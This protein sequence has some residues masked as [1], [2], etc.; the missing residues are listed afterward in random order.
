[1]SNVPD[2]EKIER[3]DRL[4]EEFKAR[5]RNTVWPDQLVNSKGVD[6]FLWH[7]SPNPTKVQRAGAVV[8]GLFFTVAAISFA[9]MALESHS[10][11]LALVALGGLYLA[12]RMLRN[13]FPKKDREHN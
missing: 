9:G 7:G 10:I 2:K 8:F 3:Q 5:Q 11:L 4:L 1:M 6:A 13:S 12:V